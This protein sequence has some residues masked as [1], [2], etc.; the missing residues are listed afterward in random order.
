VTQH[1][2]KKPLQQPDLWRYE[3]QFWETGRE[4][5]AGVDEAGRGPLAGPVVAV[6][7]ILPREF[8]I[9]GIDD[10]KALTHAQRIDLIPRIS[11]ES[12]CW[13]IGVIGPEE[14]DRFNI[15][16]ATFRAMQA[17]IAQLPQAPDAVLVDGN[18][19]I[20]DLDL[21]QRA[22]VDGDCRSVSIASASILAKEV[23]DRLMEDY[24]SQYPQFGFAK[25]KG[26]ATADHLA[27]LGRLG[28]TPI[29]RKSFTPVRNWQQNNLGI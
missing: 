24:D 17:A 8:D 10:S 3:R 19:Q 18:H 11:S 2:R 1:A 21:P 6:C 29:H 22:I 14:I 4:H 5:V 13:G 16:G 15:L 20:P 23:R 26:Y 27:A 28:P 12:L 9:T 25:H 7:V